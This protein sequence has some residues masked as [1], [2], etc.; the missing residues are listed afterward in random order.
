MDMGQ[1]FFLQCLLQ[2]GNIPVQ[3]KPA[4]SGKNPFI[5]HPIHPARLVR[6]HLNFQR[7]FRTGAQDLPFFRRILP[8][9][10]VRVKERII[11]I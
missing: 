5:V 3:V 11:Q 9:R 4:E 7:L 8:Q 1:D 6:V 2:L 10:F